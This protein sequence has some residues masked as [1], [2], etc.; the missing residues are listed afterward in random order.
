MCNLIN[1]HRHIHAHTNIQQVSGLVPRYLL[2]H[3]S[4][5]VD[6]CGEVGSDVHAL[7]KELAI[8][9]VE[10]RSETHSNESQHV[11][12][13]TEVAR[14]RRRFSFVLQQALS[15][16]PRR[17]LCRQGVALASARQLRS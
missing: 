2:A 17:H 11:A 1:T 12:E 16:R 8:R 15:F 13:G 5:Y 7:I 14:L 6:F 4:R 10:D 3:S 9:R